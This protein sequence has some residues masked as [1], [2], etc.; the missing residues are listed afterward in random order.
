MDLSIG[1]AA[2]LTGLPVKTI[3]YYSD[4]G[5]VP[6][7]WRTDAGYRRF[8]SAGLARLE[9]V[10]TLRELG[11]DLASIR[12][13]A[14]TRTSLEAVARAHAEAIDLQIHR[15]TLRRSVLRAIA[16]NGAHP[17][18]VQRMTAFAPRVRR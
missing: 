5:L 14:Q 9:L 4:I 12:L 17:E 10:R 8:D 1:E 2:R 18:E 3:R 15:L 6:E 13:I 11:I 7:A 16:R